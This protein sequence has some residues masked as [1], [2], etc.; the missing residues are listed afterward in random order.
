[1]AQTRASRR[2]RSAQGAS[3]QRHDSET[4]TRT[5]SPASSVVSE[6]SRGVWLS[7]RCAAPLY[8]LFLVANRYAA[9]RTCCPSSKAMTYGC[10]SPLCTLI[11]S[12]TQAR[13]GGIAV[14]NV[15]R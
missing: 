4:G 1:M 15:N 12:F 10:R 13:T 8:P 5:E 3:V 11:I 9:A 7:R 2:N 14:G 6:G